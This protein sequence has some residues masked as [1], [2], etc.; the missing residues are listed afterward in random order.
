MDHELPEQLV[1]MG[2][3]QL[4][5]GGLEAALDQGA[6]ACADHVARLLDG[7]GRQSLLLEDHVQGP[8]E[9]AGRIG[10]G[11]IEVEDGDGRDV[12]GV[13]MAMKVGYLLEARESSFGMIWS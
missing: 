1:E 8:D 4:L 10:Q 7:Q 2:R 6:G 9:V 13:S 12:C 5:A 11:S 3:R